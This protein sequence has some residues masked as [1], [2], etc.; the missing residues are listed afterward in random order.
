M[1]DLQIEGRFNA[2]AVPNISDPRDYKY[3]AVAGAVVIDWDRGNDIRNKLGDAI[4]YKNQEQSYSCVGQGVSYDVWVHNII[5]LMSKYSMNLAGLR[6]SYSDLISEVSA[7]SI[8]SL[9]SLGYG[10]GAYIRSGVSL[11]KDKGVNLETVVPSYK[12]DGSTDETFMIDKSWQTPLLQEVAKILRGKDYREIDAADNMDLFAQAI[13]E[14]NGLVGGCMGENNG[15]WMTESPRPPQDSGVWGHC[16]Y[17]GAFGKDKKGRFIATPNSWGN[18]LG[19]ERW[20]PGR[21][22]GFGWQ[23]FYEEWF[24]RKWMFNPTLYVDKPNET[25]TPVKYIFTKRIEFNQRCQDVTEL[26]KVLTRERLFTNSVTGYY[27]PIT[28]D[29][30]K[31]LMI[32]YKVASLSEINTVNG[33]WCGPKTIK[34]LNTL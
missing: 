13:I 1:P 10:Q 18:I 26:Q 19:A 28:Q 20:R 30:V 4:D 2:G 22:P 11:A 16:M 23:K 27:G 17:F 12:K 3:E 8:Y 9:I 25:I 31:K 7:K 33:R 29:A 6:S 21:E 5:E 14:G 24:N 15:T 32:K 34:L